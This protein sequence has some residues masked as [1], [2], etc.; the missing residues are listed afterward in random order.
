M[1]IEPTYAAWEAAVLPLN[2][3]RSAAHSTQPT[4]LT[5]SGARTSGPTP[6]ARACTMPTKLLLPP[7]RPQATSTC[8]LTKKRHRRSRGAHR[9]GL[10][11]KT[12][13]VGARLLR[14][15]HGEVAVKL[16][17]RGLH[18]SMVRNASATVT[19]G[20]KPEKPMRQLRVAAGTGFASPPPPLPQPAN[21]QAAGHTQPRRSRSRRGRFANKGCAMARALCAALAPGGRRQGNAAQGAGTMPRPCPIGLLHPTRPCAVLCCVLAAW[22]RGSSVH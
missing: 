15:R 5:I 14:H 16:L 1:G 21:S 12:H 3:T 20:G 19:R 8:A 17:H 2:Y 9:V 6:P 4:G 7:S 13:V 22:V 10:G 11:G 18:R